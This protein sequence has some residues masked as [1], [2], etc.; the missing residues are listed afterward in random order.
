MSTI[1]GTALSTSSIGRN[2]MIYTRMATQIS[3]RNSYTTRITSYT[4]C[5]TSYIY[6][7]TSLIFINPAALP[8]ALL[9]QDDQYEADRRD[10]VALPRGD[11]HGCHRQSTSLRQIDAVERRSI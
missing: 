2:N 4:L 6:R 8:E 10:Q 7:S 1:I 9:F 5:T 3:I 11:R